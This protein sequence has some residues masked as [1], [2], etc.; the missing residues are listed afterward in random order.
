MTPC[1]YVF[2]ICGKNSE[3]WKMKKKVDRKRGPHALKLLTEKVFPIEKNYLFFPLS[4][5][6]KFMRKRYEVNCPFLSMFM[7]CEQWLAFIFDWE[8]AWTAE[9]RCTA[10]S[11]GTRG[12][13]QKNSCVCNEG[14]VLLLLKLLETFL[15]FLTLCYF[16]SSAYAMAS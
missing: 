3:Q 10:A 5:P 14:N 12:V 13:Q 16:N 6:S 15:S 11:Q 8:E 4:L 9:L 7:E 2:C 1:L